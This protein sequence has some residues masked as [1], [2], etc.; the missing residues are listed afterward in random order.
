MS[1]GFLVSLGLVTA[2][3]AGDAYL[4]RR[5]L[6]KKREKEQLER[7]RMIEYNR[8]HLPP[9]ELPPLSPDISAAERVIAKAPRLSLY[10]IHEKRCFRCGEELVPIPDD[11]GEDTWT[12][13]TYI[14][15]DLNWFHS[16]WVGEGLSEQLRVLED[17]LKEKYRLSDDCISSLSFEFAQPHIF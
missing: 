9:K 16:H 4:D 6:K 12:L 15:G 14:R 13:L 10:V 5:R 1:A 17:Y 11:C 7:Q 3:M 2:L 8:T